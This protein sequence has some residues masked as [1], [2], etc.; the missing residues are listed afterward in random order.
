ML[1]CPSVKT[2][3]CHS[4]AVFTCGR[5]FLGFA[6]LRSS[7]EELRQGVGF[8]PFNFFLVQNL[9]TQSSYF[10]SLTKTDR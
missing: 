8:F 1:H 10:H 9:N 7:Y 4:S 2:E 3:A 5:F 6:I